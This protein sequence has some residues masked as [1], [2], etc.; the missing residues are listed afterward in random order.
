MILKLSGQLRNKLKNMLIRGTV[1]SNSVMSNGMNF[2]LNGP[3]EL[4]A[5][6]SFSNK[7]LNLLQEVVE[8]IQHI[9]SYFK[10]SHETYKVDIGRFEGVFPTS[11]ETNMF[12]GSEVEFSIDNIKPESWRDW[13]IQEGV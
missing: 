1:G 13:F 10:T 7:E 6:V 3:M 9:Q 11:C 12:S 4:T 2:K 5:T 8:W